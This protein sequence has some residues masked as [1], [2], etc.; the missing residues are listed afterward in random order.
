MAGKYC[1]T[2][3]QNI[4][5]KLINSY[6][7]QFGTLLNKRATI[8]VADRNDFSQMAVPDHYV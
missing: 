1:N 5:P 2:I 6:Y 8:D 3:N 4:D 7:K